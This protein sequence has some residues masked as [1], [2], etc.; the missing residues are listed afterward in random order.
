M[1]FPVDALATFSHEDLGRSAEDYMSNLLYSNPDSPE[2]FALPN[3]RQIPL[4][5]STVGIVPLYGAD[6]KHKVLALFAPEDQFTAV[7]LYLMHQWWAVEDI[8]KTANPSRNGLLEVKSLG[9]RIV[10]YVLNRI[11]YRAHEMSKNE[12]PF[13]CHSEN[14]F[15]KILWKD[16][17]AIGFYSVKPEGSLCS[18]YLTQRYQLPVLDSIFVR[19][20]HRGKGYGLQILEDFVDCFNEESLGLKYPLS[21]AMCRV[22]EQYLNKYPEDQDLLWEVEGIGGLFQRSPVTSRIQVLALKKNFQS[23]MEF[24]TSAENETLV[25]EENEEAEPTL[26]SEK[27]EE[28]KL[29][30]NSNVTE[31]VEEGIEDTPVSTRTRSN[32]YRRKRLREEVEE[33]E[34]ALEKVN[35]VETEEALVEATA[36]DEGAEKEPELQETEPPAEKAEEAQGTEEQGQTEEGTEEEQTLERELFKTSD[37]EPV[38]GEVT[39]DL[40]Q[41]SSVAEEGTTSE[42][43]D[44]PPH[45]QSDS[46]EEEA[47]ATQETVNLEQPTQKDTE[48]KDDMDESSATA[49]EDTTEEEAV[50]LEE[51]IETTTEKETPQKQDLAVPEVPLESEAEPNEEVPPEKSRSAEKDA[52]AGDAAPEE[53]R[54][55]SE[56]PSLSEEDNQQVEADEEDPSAP[57]DLSHDTLLVVG[58]K[59]VSFQSPEG[60]QDKSHLAEPGEK[61]EEQEEEKEKETA[62]TAKE[63][64]A[65]RSSD[66]VDSEPPVVDRRVLRR[67]AKT[68]RGPAK[69]R[70]KT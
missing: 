53:E 16:R 28:E 10:L 45:V 31:A 33:E 65:E 25:L 56:K 35:R 18:S 19:K 66:D 11:I 24:Q 51:Q 3:Q 37:M 39:D 70:S 14:S 41:T 1:E 60:E 29:T 5:L 9:E 54:E 40:T 36:G 4:S 8:L 58:L 46:P 30:K 59:D 20:R 64:V 21:S 34:D 47:A 13:L 49:T 32:Q 67:K 23:Q 17:E 43:S 2:Y 63:E 62:P 55:P 48:E 22:C 44:G 61:E 6:V 68:A 7:A 57:M 26:N 12:A 69:K 52:Q 27:E 42:L 38:N 50:S 15:A